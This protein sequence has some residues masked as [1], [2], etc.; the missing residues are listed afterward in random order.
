MKSLYSVQT[1]VRASREVKKMQD[2]KIRNGLRC[3]DCG[4]AM[5]GY[6]IDYRNYKCSGCGTEVNGMAVLTNGGFEQVIGALCLVGLIAL[7]ATLLK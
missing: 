1:N 5:Q 3:P 4:Q 6:S 2:L 7:F